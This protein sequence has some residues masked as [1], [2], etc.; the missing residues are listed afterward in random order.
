MK[1]GDPI[2]AESPQYQIGNPHGVVGPRA[3]D[4]LVDVTEVIKLKESDSP[5]DSI[6]IEYT[7]VNNGLAGVHLS[8]PSSAKVRK[9]VIAA[10]ADKF[11]SPATI[12]TDYSEGVRWKTDAGDFELTWSQSRDGAPTTGYGI[13]KSP[14]YLQTIADEAADRKKKDEENAA[15]LKTRL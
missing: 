6:R 11:G 9:D 4:T 14:W 12:S 3:S 2:P 15:K 1:L 7:F 13:L 8:L 5:F 10:Y